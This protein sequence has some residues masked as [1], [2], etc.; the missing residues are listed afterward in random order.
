MFFKLIAF[1]LLG[2]GL[3]LAVFGVFFIVEGFAVRHWTEVTGEVINVR[4]KIDNSL[5]DKSINREKGRRYFPEIKYRWSMEGKEYEG[6]RYRLG[7]TF[8]K[9]KTR[10]EA[11]QAAEPYTA[12][13]PV[14]VYVNPK[15]P[16]S[17]VLDRRAN[18]TY[19][20]LLIGILFLTTGALIYRF[21]DQ[22]A[23]QAQG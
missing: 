12:G 11:S 18:A 22:L 3:F 5:Q 15:D 17:A 20:P 21:R 1:G 23:A 10:G 2:F 16:N 19:I 13:G 14:A 8:E 9:F 6:D 4:I 7:T